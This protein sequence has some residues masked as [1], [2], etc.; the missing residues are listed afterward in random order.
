MTER[1]LKDK[2]AVEAFR[3]HFCKNLTESLSEKVTSREATAS[4]NDL[5]AQKHVKSE[6]NFFLQIMTPPAPL[7]ENS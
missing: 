7:Q 2:C 3:R 1:G 5:Y 6:Y 4:K